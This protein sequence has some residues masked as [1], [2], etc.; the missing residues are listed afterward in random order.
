MVQNLHHSG[1]TKKRTNIRMDEQKSENYIHVGI[2]ARGITILNLSN[3]DNSH[4]HFGSSDLKIIIFSSCSTQLSKKSGLN[5]ESD[6]VR[7]LK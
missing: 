7:P 2:N 3:R 6:T 1:I 4:T 5:F